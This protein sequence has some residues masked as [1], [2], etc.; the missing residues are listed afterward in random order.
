[1]IIANP[2]LC[3]FAAG[4]LLSMGVYFFRKIKRAAR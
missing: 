3:V 2:L 1:V 4:S